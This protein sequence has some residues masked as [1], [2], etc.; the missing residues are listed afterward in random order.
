MTAILGAYKHLDLTIDFI[1]DFR[2]RFPDIKLVVGMMGNSATYQESLTKLYG[3]KEGITLVG[4]S[5]GKRVVFSENWDA[6]INVVDT[7][8]FVFLH[9]DMY[10][11]KDF[12][13]NLDYAMS[14]L[15]S[16]CFYLYTT[17]EP[18]E[19]QGY[20]RPGKIVAPFGNDI[21]NFKEKEFYRFAQKYIGEHMDFEFQNGYGFFLAGFT[22]SLK[23]VGGFD[24]VHFRPMFCEDDDL[25]LRIRLKGYEVK[26]ITTALVYHFGSKTV[27]LDT[28]ASMSGVEV[29]SNRNFSRKWGFEARYLWETG[30]ENM[31][32][33]S[34]GT[35]KI[36]YTYTGTFSNKGYVP[37]AVEVINAE[38]LVDC[39]HIDDK[40]DTGDYFNGELS[41][42]L[43]SDRE[44][45]D[46]YLT[47]DGPFDFNQFAQ[48]IGYLRFGHRH[49]VPGHARIGNF[50]IDVVNVRSEESRV[51]LTNY[52]LE[53]KEIH[54]D[55]N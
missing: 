41:K 23:D 20:P 26:V 37:S 9:N 54:Y 36:K 17:V 44:E 5:Y 29:E 27:R 34:I 40:V 6:A 2:K 50:E 18:L 13:R 22:D 8:R 32:E 42:K 43:V 25:N 14:N 11:H 24:F 16:K 28:D 46:I 15:G 55:E 47:Q 1:D 10:I 30:Y 38:P 4:G 7:E 53:Q 39:L 12:F 19:F 48:L 33:I 31:K 52:L 35:E 51:D 3:G 21:A 49:L 45:A